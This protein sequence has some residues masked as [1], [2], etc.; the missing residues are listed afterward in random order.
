MSDTQ[1]SNEE[2]GINIEVESKPRD[3]IKE[4]ETVIGCVRHSVYNDNEFKHAQ[5]KLFAF[6]VGLLCGLKQGGK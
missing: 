2:V 6:N 3:L 1:R 5:D 4:L